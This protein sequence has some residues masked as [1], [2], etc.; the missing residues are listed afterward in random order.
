MVPI[1]FLAS[2][3]GP[4]H[5]VPLASTVFATVILFNSYC[6]MI[7]DFNIYLMPEIYLVFSLMLNYMGHSIVPSL[8][9]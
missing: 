6:V 8:T 1:A 5:A 4:G 2:S 3:K 9:A 7:T